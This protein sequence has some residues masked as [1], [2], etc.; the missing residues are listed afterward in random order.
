MPQPGIPGISTD[1]S[2]CLVLS[3]VFISEPTIVARGM[4]CIDWCRLSLNAPTLGP[5]GENWLHPNSMYLE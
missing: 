5:G 4:E 1:W 2:Y 3:S